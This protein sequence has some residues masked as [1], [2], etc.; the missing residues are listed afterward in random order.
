MTQNQIAIVIGVGPGLGAG[1]VRR[2][3]KAGMNVAMV[4]RDSSKLKDLVQE[5]TQLGGSARAYYGDATDAVAVESLFSQV[6]AD[7]GCPNLVVYNAST[8]QPGNILEIDPKDFDRCWR[9][10]CFGGFLVGQAAARLMTQQGHGTILF[11]GASASL[12]GSAGFANLAVG[13]FGLRAVAQSMAR[14]VASQGVHV[15]HIIIDGQIE[16]ERYSHLALSRGPDALLAPDAIAESY[17]QL[18]LQHR[19]AWTQELDLRPWV[20]K[21]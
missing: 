10:S 7:Y 2:F 5:A 1:L 12:R 17:Y 8:Y 11:T 3:A 6:Q 19:S 21:F 16:S 15:A 9:V 20:E 18:H 14:E 13:K 4:A